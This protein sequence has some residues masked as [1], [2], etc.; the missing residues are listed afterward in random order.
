[1]CSFIVDYGALDLLILDK[2]SQSDSGQNF[3]YYFRNNI[4][5]RHPIDH[6]RGSLDICADRSEFV[7]H[8]ID[9]G[10]H[11][12]IR[13]YRI[14]HANRHELLA[15]RHPSRATHNLN[16]LLSEPVLLE[17]SGSRKRRVSA[18]VESSRLSGRMGFY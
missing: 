14:A 8:S 15:K 13:M 4:S 7:R 18:A 17:H 5:K 1:M 11:P 10:V 3:D 6:S 9:D 16:L 2:R 12:S